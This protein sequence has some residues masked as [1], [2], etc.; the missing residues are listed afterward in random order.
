MIDFVREYHHEFQS[1]SGKTPEFIN[2]ARKAKK[3]FSV[4][5]KQHDAILSTWNI[6]HFYVSGFITMS[7]GCI[8]YFSSS[9]VRYKLMSSLLIRTAKHLKDYTGGI[10]QS[11]DFNESFECNFNRIIN[12]K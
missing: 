2:W 12:S 1:S 6:G 11:V 9:D 4:W 7:N 5:C 8:W 10:N 3:W